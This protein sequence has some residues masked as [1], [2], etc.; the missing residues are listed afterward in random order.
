MRRDFTYIDD[1]VDGTLAALDRPVPFEVFNLGNSEPVDLL[2]FIGLLEEALGQ[3]AEKRMMPMQPGDV[4]ETF[5]DIQDAKASLGFSPRTPLREGITRFV[6]WYR[7][8]YGRP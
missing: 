1:I 3:K 2:V 8:H 4:P 7:S 5:A 6:A